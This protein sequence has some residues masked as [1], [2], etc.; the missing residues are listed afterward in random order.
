MA[1]KALLKSAIT[2]SIIAISVHI[3]CSGSV[4]YEPIL[5]NLLLLDR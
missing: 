2:I 3:S 4:G 5:T 1:K